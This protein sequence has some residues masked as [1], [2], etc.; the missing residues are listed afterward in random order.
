MSFLK[1][2]LTDLRQRRLWPV[3]LALIA[4][5]VAVPVLLGKQAPPPAPLPLSHGPVAGTPIAAVSVNNSPS[6]SQPSGPARDPFTQQK[7]PK[8]R[9]GSSPSGSTAAS[10]TTA[11]VS[12]T[13]SGSTTS[14]SISSGG[15]SPS[16][17]SV[18]SSPATPPVS[19]VAPGAK[20]KPAPTGLTATQS[21]DVALS[22]TNPKG[23]LDQIDPLERLS[24]LPSDQQPLLVELGVLQGGK[25]VAFAVQ[26]GTVVTGGGTCTPGP[27]DC[28]IFTVGQDQTVTVSTQ[29]ASGPVYVAEFAIIGITAKNDGSAAVADQA[30]REQSA[31]GRKLLDNSSS[32][33]LSLFQYDPTV[34]AVVDLRNLTV[35]GN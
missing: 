12:T 26:P 18:S 34:G 15:V 31:A 7:Q 5:I 4:A 32:N 2:I 23:G 11:S 28:E 29:S 19:P 35:G 21:Y 24:V 17:S 14:S 30:R 25:R 8:P 27:I 3:P 13:S 22:I 10:G 9:T 16:T 6:S 20:P 33:A 1:G